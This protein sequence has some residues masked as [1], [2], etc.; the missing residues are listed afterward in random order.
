MTRTL[1]VAMTVSVLLALCP[2]V[3]RGTVS[4]SATTDNSTVNPHADTDHCGSCHI[5][6]KDDL[7]RNDVATI[8]KSELKGGPVEVCRQCHGIGFGHGVGK[9]PAMNREN[10]PLDAA[11]VITCALTC[12]D[13]HLAEAKDPRQKQYFLRL[14]SDT[15]CYSCHDK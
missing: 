6:V 4:L 2:Y 13:I 1:L 9:K 11:G 7:L 5:L 12:H 14:P 3:S 10:L 15:L 8:K